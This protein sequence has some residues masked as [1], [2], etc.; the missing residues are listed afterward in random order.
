MK[1]QVAGVLQT[2]LISLYFGVTT[3]WPPTDRLINAD[4][5]DELLENVNVDLLFLA[6][7]TFEEI[8]QSQTSLEKMKKVQ[9]A[10]YAGGKS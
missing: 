3:I 10:L 5:I 7:S 2:L 8:S 9:Y 6:P 4:L 1:F